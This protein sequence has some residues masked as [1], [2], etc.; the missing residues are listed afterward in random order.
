MRKDERGNPARENHKIQFNG[1]MY[2]VIVVDTGLIVKNVNR[3]HGVFIELSIESSVE[4]CIE[5]RR[6]ETRG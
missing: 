6:A 1:T 3:K 5:D 2:T 4:E